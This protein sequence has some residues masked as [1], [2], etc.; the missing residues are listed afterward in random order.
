MA[1]ENHNTLLS[2]VDP[3]NMLN[4]RLRVNCKYE[5]VN[6]RG[7]SQTDCTP[8][9]ERALCGIAAPVISKKT[10]GVTYCIEETV[11]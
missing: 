2:S 6:L 10:E 11:A 7:L 9:R 4:S 8:R 1:T 3:E 5:Y